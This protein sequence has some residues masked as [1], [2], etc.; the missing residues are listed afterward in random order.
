MNFQA[1]MN[2]LAAGRKVQRNEW[3]TSVV[4]YTYLT[5]A[6]RQLFEL[7]T[8]A[9]G[10]GTAPARTSA[11]APYTPSQ[12]DMTASDWAVLD[13]P[14]L[15]LTSLVN[16]T[17]LFFDAL[18][19]LGLGTPTVTRGAWVTSTSTPYITLATR[20]QIEIQTKSKT[21]GTPPTYSTTV[22]SPYTP[23]QADLSALDW[24]VATPES[25]Q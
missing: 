25:F 8:R 13:L 17:G 12:G 6:P 2:E 11:P 20:S 14:S 4:A 24:I 1:A 3:V 21:M 15:R 18:R 23:S 22:P 19:L 7:Q 9:A 5:Q 10:Y 16:G